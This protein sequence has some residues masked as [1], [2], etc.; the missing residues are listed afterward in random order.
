MNIQ[1]FA[2]FLGQ[3]QT[4][5]Q[6]IEELAFLNDSQQYIMQIRKLSGWLATKW[7]WQVVKHKNTT[8]SMVNFQFEEFIKISG[9]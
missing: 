4:A 6:R 2:D 5:K 3:C 8:K 7:N 1:K 9:C